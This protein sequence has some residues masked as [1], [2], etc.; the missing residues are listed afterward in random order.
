FGLK[1]KNKS[2]K[3][4]IE[5]I[6][7]SNPNIDVVP[8]ISS[9]LKEIRATRNYNPTQ[10]K[11]K[12]LIKNKKNELLEFL[13]E[14]NVVWEQVKSKEFFKPEYNFVYDFTV[15]NSHNF[16]AN[17]I[18]VHNTASAVKD[19]FGEGGWTLKAGALV[20]ASGGLANID[21]FDKMDKEDRSAMHEAMEQQMVSIAKAGIV[22][23]FK[24]ET[25]IL[26]AANPKFSRF[27]PY[28]PFIKQIDL[29]STLISRFDL[30]F[31]IR[32]VLDKVKDEEITASILK[33]H[34]AGEMM[35]QKGKRG[36]KETDEMEELKKLI[37]PA[38]DTELLKKYIS[39][40]RQKISPVL[41]AEAIKTL[42]DFYLG[43]R[44]M[45][46]KEGSYAATHRQ[47]EGLVRLSEASARVRLSD[48][49]EK[50]DAEKAVKLLKNS[51][52]DVVT[53]PETGRIDM[54]II[55]IGTTHSKL[56]AL[57]NVLNIVRQK[58]KE[59]DLVPIIE[60]IEEAKTLGLEKERVNE[61]ISEL[62]R[63]GELYEKKHGFISPVE[64]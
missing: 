54:D 52:Q 61:I 39:F 44:E 32:D 63:K 40:A 53:D 38:I 51:L 1:R 11:L 62:K 35:L 12:E 26:A 59:Q 17:G 42:T 43:L 34:K 46:K 64:K 27:D 50:S 28:E 16:I 7:I 45:G 10:E 30:F 58:S 8:E 20:L 49:I 14:S 47:L 23:R 60:V 22:T 33:T 2:L 15:E 19:D 6:P 31:M 13:S 36:K 57:R 56:T 21:E 37:T 3:G 9:L 18:I 29:P 4:I 48:T 55:N 41:S 5:K 25:S 24:T